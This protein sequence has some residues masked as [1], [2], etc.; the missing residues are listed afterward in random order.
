MKCFVVTYAGPFGF[1][2]PWTAV[3][4]IRTYSQTF[5]TPSIVEGL[6]QKLE[7]SAIL[8]H[9]LRHNGISLQ[10]E[11]TQASGWSMERKKMSRK[12]AIIER[13][14][15]IQPSL[16]LVFPS[17]ED[18]ERAAAQHIC[19]CRN[20]DVLLPT[21]SVATMTIEEF[22]TIPGI[23]LV[24]GEGLDSFLVGFNRFAD[25]EPMYGSLHIVEEEEQ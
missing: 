10:L 12:V 1:I 22:D 4:D 11:K 15:L 5:L 16:S 13:G 17:I 3:R 25:A 14:V 7:V 9:R 19:L 23:E 8:R 24:F 20:E 2:K 21:S 6:R 18:A